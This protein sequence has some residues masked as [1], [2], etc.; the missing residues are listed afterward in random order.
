[1]SSKTKPFDI[2]ASEIPSCQN[3][4]KCYL[5]PRAVRTVCIEHVSVVCYVQDMDVT[6]HFTML[7]T[8]Q[9]CDPLHKCQQ[10]INESGQKSSKNIPSHV[11]C[12][13]L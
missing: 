3:T 7:A 12:T 8:F 13:I 9:T 4:R 1:M 5:P 6:I 10:L 2:S 11:M